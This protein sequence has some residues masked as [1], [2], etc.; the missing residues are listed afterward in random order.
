MTTIATLFTGFG[1][2]DIGAINAGLVPLWGI[3]NRPDV[4]AVANANLGGH[5]IVADV[6]DVDPHTLER[7]EVL[8]ASPPCPRFSLA[9]QNK[10]E[11]NEDIALGQAVARFIRVLRPSVFT[12]ENVYLYRKSKSWAIIRQALNECGYWFDLAHVDAA[13]FGVPQNRR[14]MWV[15]ALLGQMIPRLSELEPWQGWY[16][17][18]EDLIPNLPDSQFAEW[19]LARGVEELARETT[20]VAQG[21]FDHTNVGNE[22]KPQPLGARRA[23]QPAFTVTGNSSMAG[24]RAFVVDG[25]NSSGRVAQMTPRCGARWQTFPDGYKLSGNNALSWYGIGNAVPPLLYQKL[26]APLVNLL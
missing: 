25:Q 21:S 22:R 26:V 19:Q 12:L 13:D 2:V 1:G 14:R 4:A 7:P 15:R 3:E 17:A 24:M 6:L 18:I 5:I 10:G 20:L 23:D 8:H 9:N 16:Q 11:T